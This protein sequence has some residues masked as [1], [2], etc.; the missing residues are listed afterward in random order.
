MYIKQDDMGLGTT[1][2]QWNVWYDVRVGSNLEDWKVFA[3]DQVKRLED[4][5]DLS[6]VEEM[7]FS[8]LVKKFP[9]TQTE[10][11]GNMWLGARSAAFRQCWD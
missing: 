8:I 1:D 3:P 10:W 9:S 2:G 7:D 5:L 4:I 11:S 6:E